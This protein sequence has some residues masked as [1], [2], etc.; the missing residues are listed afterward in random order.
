MTGTPDM[1]APDRTWVRRTVAIVVAAGLVAVTW[2]DVAVAQQRRA[3]DRNV[4]AERAERR[5][6][7]AFLAKLT[8]VADDVYRA[9]A[10]VQAVLA[11]LDNPGPD[12]MFAA[13]DAL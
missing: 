4:A 11:A 10:P 5:A 1:P 6:E 2:V 13:R 9:A 12:D 8:P 3:H 7:R